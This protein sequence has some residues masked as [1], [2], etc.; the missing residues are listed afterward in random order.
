MPVKT[1]RRRRWD[2]G[3]GFEA[4]ATGTHPA[5]GLDRRDDDFLLWPLG[6]LVSSQPIEG[7]YKRNYCFYCLVYKI[8]GDT[9]SIFMRIVV[10]WPRCSAVWAWLFR[11]VHEDRTVRRKV[12]YILWG[13]SKTAGGI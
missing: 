6:V 12:C 1:W 7:P 9:I 10:G 3:G 5:G 8:M 4:R 13:S 2:E 11:R